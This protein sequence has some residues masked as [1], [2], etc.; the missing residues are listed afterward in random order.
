MYAK[1]RLHRG[2][3]AL[4]LAV[5]V[6]PVALFAQLPEQMLNAPLPTDPKVKI[7]KLDPISYIQIVENR[8]LRVDLLLTL[9]SAI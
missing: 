2:L 7:G 5:F 9:E 6:C 8:A 4:L 1:V 3:L